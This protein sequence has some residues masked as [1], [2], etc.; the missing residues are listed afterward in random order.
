M[1][2]GV[3]NTAVLHIHPTAAGHIE[4]DRRIHRPEVGT[5]LVN[6]PDIA[7]A[8]AAEAATKGEEGTTAGH[9]RIAVDRTDCAD[10]AVVEAGKIAVHSRQTV[11]GHIAADLVDLGKSRSRRANRIAAGL[12]LDPMVE[13]DTG[14]SLAVHHT[15]P[16]RHADA[17]REDAGSA[18][19]D[20]DCIDQT[21][22]RYHIR[23]AAH[24]GAVADCTH[25]AAA[26]HTG[27][28]LG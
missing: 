10:H 14:C 27:L 9:T 12:I 7:D 3:E 18:V 13:E 28:D 1:V 8:G 24:T 15:H 11:V 5:D 21:A 25:G 16:I 4:V 6:R 17:D 23:L 20:T 26:S 22:H 19:V 2:E